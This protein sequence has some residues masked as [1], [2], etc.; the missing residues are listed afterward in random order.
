MFVTYI[1][2]YVYIYPEWVEIVF[3]AWVIV[4]GSIMCNIVS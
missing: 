2:M 3:F 1:T 4:E